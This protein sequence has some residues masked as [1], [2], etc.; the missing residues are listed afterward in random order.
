[1]RRTLTVI[2]LLLLLGSCG[3]H[4]QGTPQPPA[5]QTIQVKGILAKK[6]LASYKTL[7]LPSAPFW[8]PQVQLLDD[9]S[10]TK[11]LVITIKLNADPS[12]EPL[13]SKICEGFAETA[14]HGGVPTD[15]FLAVISADGVKMADC[16]AQQPTP[17]APKHTGPVPPAPDQELQ[18]GHT[19]TLYN[20]G[21]REAVRVTLH[22]LSY[23][24][25]KK[26]ES[27]ANGNVF[28]LLEM[29]IRNVGGKS[30]YGT[31]VYPD[32]EGAD[33]RFVADTGWVIA[34]FGNYAAGD[35]STELSDSVAPG[36][37]LRGFGL[38]EIPADEPGSLIFPY[39]PSTMA[40]PV[41]PQ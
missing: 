28:V 35:Y 13:A 19:I 29:T 37:Y 8:A 24:V 18:A 22:S 40:I 3:R 15:L 1:M 10:S 31:N 17:P 33:G 26:Y 21:R 27:P 7:I 23:P 34:P 2:I 12:V 16:V 25:A 36:Q 9:E 4:S 39:G 38:Y 5:Q 14:G 11:S 20:R 30:A 41:A 6:V 32:W